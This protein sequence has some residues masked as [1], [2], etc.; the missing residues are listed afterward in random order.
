[1]A[2]VFISYKREERARVEQIA[3]RLKGLGLS[4]WFDSRL[5]SGESFDEEINREVHAA[6]C[7]MVCWSPGAVQ[8]QW[9]RAEAAIGRERDVLATVMLAPTKLYPPFNL[10]HTIDLSKWDGRDTD[11]AWLATIGRIGAL[12]DRPDLVERAG[13]F[14][15]LAGAD[16]TKPKKSRLGLWL[17]LIAAFVVVGAGGYYVADTYFNRPHLAVYEIATQTPEPG[18]GPNSPVYFNGIEVGYVDRLLIDRDDSRIVII[19]LLINASA[20]IREDTLA[21]IVTVGIS[22]GINLSSGSPQ[23]PL[24]RP[25]EN[26]PPPRIPLA[27]DVQP[28]PTLAEPVEDAAIGPPADGAATTAPADGVGAAV[29]A[30]ADGAA[31]TP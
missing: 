13:K 15:G 3:E 5:P 17:A 20:P 12:A 4:V 14:A 31:T 29:A 16:L 1:M 25:Q 8:S 18:I 23:T 19:R 22:R 9:V 30:P 26:G 6:K 7:V 10:I 2:D 24:R 27:S 21:T 11:P 28:E